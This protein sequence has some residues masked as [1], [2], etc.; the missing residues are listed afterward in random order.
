[1]RYEDILLFWFVECTNKRRWAKDRT[2]DAMVKRRFES[3]YEAARAGELSHWRAGI[4][5]RMAEIILL[6]QFSRN[7]FR[8]TA[9]AF[10]SDAMALVLAQ[11]ALGTG[12]LMTLKPEERSFAVM[13]YMHS[14][15]RL[16]QAQS[17]KVFEALELEENLSFAIRHKE[18]IDQFD[19]FPHRNAILNRRSTPEEIEFLAQPGSSF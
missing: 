7:M 6:D 2:F 3:I 10:E 12:L 16:V 4:R 9:R 15:S 5:G 8:D 18:I 17:V 11:E 1:M 14:E 13:P 19:R